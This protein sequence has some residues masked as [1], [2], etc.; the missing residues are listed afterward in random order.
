[1]I[2]PTLLVKMLK[3]R[4]LRQRAFLGPIPPLAPDRSNRSVMEGV[5]AATEN[6]VEFLE[7][8][9]HECAHEIALDKPP[10]G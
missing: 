2:K 1:M 8:L 9:L 6:E 3:S 7:T 10:Q 5:I 4:L